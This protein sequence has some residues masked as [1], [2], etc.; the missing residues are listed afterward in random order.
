MCGGGVG[1][2]IAVTAVFRDK[3]I[4]RAAERQKSPIFNAYGKSS[5]VEKKPIEDGGKN[6]SGRISDEYEK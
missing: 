2:K 6:R 3:A 1:T 5:G 4:F